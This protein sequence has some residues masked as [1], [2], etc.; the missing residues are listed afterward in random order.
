[1]NTTSKP[2]IVAA[3]LVV[4]S[5]GIV[6]SVGIIAVWLTAEATVLPLVIPPTA[7]VAPLLVVYFDWRAK[8]P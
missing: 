8:L 1:V 5:I 4:A 2:A 6:L 7:I 3:L